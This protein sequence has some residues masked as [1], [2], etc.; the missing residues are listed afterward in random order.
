MASSK[1]AYGEHDLPEHAARLSDEVLAGADV[2]RTDAQRKAEAK[3]RADWKPPEGH[4]T[5][6]DEAIV[7][8]GDVLIVDESLPA[9]GIVE[10]EWQQPEGVMTNHTVTAGPRDVVGPEPSPQPAKAKAGSPK[11]AGDNE[12]KNSK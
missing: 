9:D 11:T 10:R 7:K 1:P 5:Q 3:R 8:T 6:L 2:Y 12:G 4:T